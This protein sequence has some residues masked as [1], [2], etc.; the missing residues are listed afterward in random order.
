MV[1]SMGVVYHKIS[2]YK[3]GS[4]NSEK[5]FLTTTMTSDE[6]FESLIQKSK[7]YTLKHLNLLPESVSAKIEYTPGSMA[8]INAGKL[9]RINRN[10][11]GLTPEAVLKILKISKN[12]IPS[13]SIYRL[14]VNS[15]STLFN[16]TE[17][18][19]VYS[20][21]KRGERLSTKKKISNYVSVSKENKD[22]LYFD[23]NEDVTR[24]I[25]EHFKEKYGLK[26]RKEFLMLLFEK[27]GKLQ[28]VSFSWKLTV[29]GDKKSVRK[30]DETYIW[31]ED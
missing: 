12:D 8:L 15:T 31:F 29:T 25:Y 14:T 1:C 10:I 23:K 26:S 7:L 16:I 19:N 21:L 20:G 9:Y 5:E 27:N 24:D 4:Y 18:Y 17:D 30:F 11:H 2:I 3:D 6:I 22:V 13:L 28:T